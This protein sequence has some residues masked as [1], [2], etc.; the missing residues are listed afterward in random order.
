MPS[1]PSIE[2]LTLTVFSAGGLYFLADFA[3]RKWRQA[4]DAPCSFRL[5]SLGCAANAPNVTCALREGRW[6]AGCLA[7]DEA[8]APLARPRPPRHPPV[9][10]GASLCSSARADDDDY[11]WMIGLLAAAACWLVLGAAV[12]LCWLCGGVARQEEEGDAPSAAREKP[13]R[14]AAAASQAST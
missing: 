13:S 3:L 12:L 11:A 5:S 9:L 8:G 7:F 1:L 10:P 2:D 6:W 4:A 14:E